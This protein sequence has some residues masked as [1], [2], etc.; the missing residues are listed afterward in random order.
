MS[1]SRES[2]PFFLFLFP[3]LYFLL[4]LPPIFSVLHAKIRELF[5]LAI[6]IPFPFCHLPKSNRAILQRKRD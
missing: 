6:S 2:R 4:V 3:F 5:S 1:P